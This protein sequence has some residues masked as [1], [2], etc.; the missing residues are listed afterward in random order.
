MYF[1]W[2][3]ADWFRIPNAE[4]SAGA[5]AKRINFSVGSDNFY[6][7]EYALAQDVP[8][9]YY[10]NAD[11][12]LDFRN[13]PAL[14]IV[15][16]L[17]LVW[18]DRIATKLLTTT[19]HTSSTTLTNAW[20]DQINSDPISDIFTGKEAIRLTTGKDANKMIISGR[21]WNNMR[22]HPLVIDF[23]R[24]KGD[25]V[26]GG[27]VSL[28]QVANAFELSEVLLGR[29]I[30]NTTDEGQTAS[31]TEIWSTACILLHVAPN[32]GKMVPSHGYTFQW[33]PQGLPGPWAVQRYENRRE[34]TES[35]EVSHFQDEKITGTDLGY[36][37]LNA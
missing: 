2:A 16:E 3:K 33:R 26:G 24:G 10:A 7:K 12:A 25:S 11:E 34:S 22:Q 30:K 29:G 32:P 4:R 37:I 31:F 6:C 17:G 36:L 21:S 23:I 28:Q 18:E 5:P 15:D 27:A 1:V 9:Q 8:L 19:N 14:H 20:S 13:A 35:I